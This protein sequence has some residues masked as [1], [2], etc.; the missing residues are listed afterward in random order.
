VTTN[1]I[2]S[3]T[4]QP[5]TTA[6][7]GLA[8]LA[9][10]GALDLFQLFV[11][12]SPDSAPVGVVLT[13]SGLGVVTLLG[14]AAAWRGSRAGLVVAVAAR[15]VDSVLGIPAFFLGAPAWVLALIAAMLVLSVVGVVLVAPDL[16]RGKATTVAS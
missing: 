1:L 12:G 7:A 3:G 16:R 9:A 13:T 15:V 2:T 6:K 4:H 14:V 5:T 11:L 10:A 8:A